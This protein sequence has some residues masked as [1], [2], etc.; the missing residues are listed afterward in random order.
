MTI[1]II[2]TKLHI[3]QLPKSLVPR[4][5]L[6]D[7]LETGARGKL[8]LVSAPAGFGKTS[9]ISELVNDPREGRHV[10]WVHLDEN[11]NGL[12]HFLG[13]V[14]AALQTHHPDIGEAS[15]SGLQSVPPVPIEAILTSLIN[16]IDTL[17]GQIIL[18]LDDYHLIDA[19]SIHESVGFLI[20]H[21]PAHMCL[22]IV[23]RI[24]PPLPLHRLRARG[25]MMEIRAQDLRF[26]REEMRSLL[27]GML[28]MKFA[29]EDIAA[30]DAR[31]EG[32]AAGLQMVALSLQG[33]RDVHQF[34]KSFS[35]SHRYIMDYL[36]EE[37][38]DQ[39]PQHIKKFLL[40]TSILD[41]LSGPLCEA[42]LRTG[43]WELESQGDTF[44]AQHML[45][46]LEQAN[47]FLLPLD[48]ERNWYRYH[49]LF[50][51]LL[52]QRLRQTFPDE[53]QGLQRRA[54]DWFVDQGYFEEAFQYALQANDSQAAANIVEGQGLA[55]LKQ[56]SLAT[57]FGWFNRL[58][59][60]I[61]RTQPRLNVIYAWALLLSG[62]TVDLEEYLTAAEGSKD[63]VG[64]VDELH[65]EIAAIRAYAA[66]RR[67][68]IDLSLEQAHKALALLPE[69]DYSVRSVV[70]FVMG[71]VYYLQGDVPNALEA[72]NDAAQNGERSGNINVA[73]SAVNAMA[74]ML[75]GQG[76]LGEAENNYAR[77]LKLGTGRS[78]RPLPVAGSIYT[79]LARLHLALNDL[80]NAREYATTGFEL[81]EIWMNI[82][83]QINSLLVLAQV[84]QLEGN[85]TE[86]LQALQQ[87]RHLAGTHVL[88]PGTD[89]AIENV[90]MM[91]KTQEAG[92]IPQG[93]LVEPLSERELEVLRLM[94]EGRT[95]AEIAAELIIA[96]GTVKAHTSSIYRKLDVRNRTQ[97]IVAA[98]EM[99]LL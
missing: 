47:L 76:K 74:G 71:G 11:D 80:S 13:Y 20:E 24:D 34:I 41:R 32:W 49:H 53:I 39:Q 83:S 56:G 7:R 65:G 27:E 79:G 30:L 26:S 70:S 88:T 48:E 46:D 42:V 40:G 52:R 33:K 86:A 93:A 23:T 18:V 22:V 62:E 31:V 38:Y 78:G 15:L 55:M 4:G 50:A 77:G 6:I 69:D 64:D 82:E 75:M 91:I 60:A 59:E 57:I 35:G 58:P 25:Q 43:P 73:V 10:S 96:L 51:D 89:A 5:P 85:N 98:R 2:S 84:A 90:A 45:E 72:M 54:S 16:E 95:N 12:T 44:T 8:I 3:P 9:L 17:G 99:N 21:L 19:S 36:T 37:I 28:G 14:I 67:E 29:A 87:A 61:V 81:G 63:D 68:D 94:A 97:A 66:A 92:S 1:P